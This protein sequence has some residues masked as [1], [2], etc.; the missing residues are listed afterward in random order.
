M[1]NNH[2]PFNEIE[3]NSTGSFLKYGKGYESFFINKDKANCEVEKCELYNLRE[4]QYC[5]SKL[6]ENDI[7]I[8]IGPEFQIYVSETNP[9]GYEQ[10]F[11]LVCLVHN[12]DD[13]QYI[14]IKNKYLSVKSLPLDCSDSL[15]PTNF[16]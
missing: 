9:L 15:K 3:Y 5:D 12:K 6:E 10:K 1:K 8:G 13:K 11:C 16:I 2:F 4:N 14:E 7:K